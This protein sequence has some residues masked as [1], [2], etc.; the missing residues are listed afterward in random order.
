MHR[1]SSSFWNVSLGSA[2]P[3]K[4]KA[5]QVNNKLIPFTTILSLTTIIVVICNY[6]Y[7]H[8]NCNYCNI[9]DDN[10]LIRSTKTF[11]PLN[12]KSSQIFIILAVL[13]RS[14]QRKV[15][16]CPWLNALAAQLRKNV[17][18]VASR[19]SIWQ[20]RQSNPDLPHR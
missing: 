3:E 6:N 1:G 14:V 18:A 20:A 5:L 7:N 4:L 9:E 16:S 19:C 12:V 17:A 8:N 13:R 2:P 15:G 10:T 11:L